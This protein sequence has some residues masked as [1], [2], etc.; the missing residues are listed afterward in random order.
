MGDEQGGLCDKDE[1]AALNCFPA[2]VQQI[3]NGDA[4]QRTGQSFCTMAL[5]RE[6][7]NR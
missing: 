6:R 1:K 4:E 2:S 5:T 3:C 7:S